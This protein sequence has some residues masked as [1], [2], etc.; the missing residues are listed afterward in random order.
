MKTLLLNFIKQEKC[1]QTLIKNQAGGGILYGITAAVAC[2]SDTGPSI[3]FIIIMRWSGVTETRSWYNT[4]LLLI[5]KFHKYIN[6]TT[7][8]NH[9]KTTTI[10]YHRSAH[11]VQYKLN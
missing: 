6:K 9:K 8:K 1:P 3:F 5:Q 4:F 11:N 2:K 10:S 7:K